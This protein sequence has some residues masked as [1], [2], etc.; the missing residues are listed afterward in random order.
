MS[1]RKGHRVL[2][3]GGR[4]FTDYDLLYC[5]LSTGMSSGELQIGQTYGAI[6]H[7]AARGADS[8]ASRFASEMGI[9]CI[10]FPADWRKH[11]KAAGFIRN[12]QML[13]EGKPDI[14][15]AFPGGRGTADMV[16]RARLA[17]VEIHE[18]KDGCPHPGAQNRCMGRVCS[19]RAL[20]VASA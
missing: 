12:Q 4:D 9:Q 17:G 8:L 14:V 6:I 16:R 20:P 5:T 2:V 13:S 3:C 7:G 1:E 10:S 11:G 19:N 18:V 15:I